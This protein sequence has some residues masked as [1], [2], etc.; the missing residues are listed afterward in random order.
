MLFA[1][2]A[3]VLLAIASAAALSSGAPAG[4]YA[5]HLRFSPGERL[6]EHRYLDDRV[7]WKLPH[8]RLEPFIRAGVVIHEERHTVAIVH[9]TAVSIFRGV[10]TFRAEA[11]V[12]TIDVP[13]DSRTTA[14]ATL[15]VRVDEHN[16]PHPL[17]RPDVEDAAMIGLPA[18]P[19]G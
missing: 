13:R 1:R 5:L 19:V 7:E 2:F 4:G 9:A 12:T 14:A 11:S 17:D 8:K 16:V 10:A 3:P 18:S 6:V 15:S